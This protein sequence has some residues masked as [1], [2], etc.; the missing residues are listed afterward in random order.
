MRCRMHEKERMDTRSDDE[1]EEVDVKNHAKV[2]RGDSNHS[3][4]HYLRVE[5]WVS[6]V[7]AFTLVFTLLLYIR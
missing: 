1:A 5:T 2:G 3:F 6:I 4:I 7:Q